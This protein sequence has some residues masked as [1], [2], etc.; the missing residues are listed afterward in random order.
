MSTDL[1]NRVLRF[2]EGRAMKQMQS[3]VSQVNDREAEFQARSDDEL[4]AFATGLME[5]GANGEPLD[6]LMV[7][8]IYFSTDLATLDPA[9]R[10]T[11]EGFLR[12]LLERILR[13]ALNDALPAI[14]IPSFTLPSSVSAYGLPAGAVLGI[15]MPT[16]AMEP[17]HVVLRGEFAVR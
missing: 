10:D 14:P 15:V 11:I 17:P 3:V 7:E 4:R 16:M 8:E 1:I 9:T 12:R 6:D 13:P 5:R 2:G